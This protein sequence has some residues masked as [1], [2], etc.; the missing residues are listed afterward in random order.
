[1]WDEFIKDKEEK[2]DLKEVDE[3]KFFKKIR[4]S[5]G[6]GF[7]KKKN[8]T[9]VSNIENDLKALDDINIKIEFI[10]HNDSGSVSERLKYFKKNFDVD[11]L[12]E[13]YD[14][15]LS[16]HIISNKYESW[17]ILNIGNKS[18]SIFWV[19]IKGIGNKIYENF[20]VLPKR[21]TDIELENGN[22][23]ILAFIAGADIAHIGDIVQ[24]EYWSYGKSPIDSNMNSE[25]RIVELTGGKYSF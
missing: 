3:E 14:G 13:Y 2:N 15:N 5:L 6:Q 10:K 24:N 4:N 19:R 11:K 20:T 1:M 21:Q 7:N 23:E 22:Y 8:E 18:N 25:V 12:P 17:S 16:K 9:E